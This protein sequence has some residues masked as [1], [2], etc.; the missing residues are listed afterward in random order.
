MIPNST[1]A[2][3]DDTLRAWLLL[4]LTPRIGIATMLKLIHHFGSADCIIDQGI[5]TLSQFIPKTIARLIVD[6]TAQ[7]D[8]EIALDWVN[9]AKNRYLISL[10]NPTYPK[11]LA[12]ISD[13]PLILYAE[14]NLSLLQENKLAIVGTRHPTAQG[15]ENATKFAK[16][17]AKNLTIVSGMALGIDRH[18]HIGAL[19]SPKSTIGV[20]GTGIDLVYPSSNKDIFEQVLD[21]G[22][23]IS[24]LPLK[25]PALMN[26]F[27][28]R[29]RIIAGLSKG[30][31][32][33]ESAKDGGSLITAN[34]ALDMG[35]EVM[36]IPGSIYNPVACGCH[37]LIKNGAKLIE[38]TNDVLEEL[39]LDQVAT[40]KK[41]STT[42]N[43]PLLD[44]M[45]FD[46]IEIDKICLNSNTNFNDICATL[47]DLELNGHIINCG[48][49]KYQR[50]FR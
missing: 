23:L 13:P 5:D 17:L 7:K 12:Q 21:K 50:V 6:K 28:R 25:T 9:K 47:L 31:L 26:N 29:N 33:I 41:N 27:P 20:I 49:G 15:I 34:C 35:R 2:S 16:D 42:F 1:L 46:P 39:I 8:V 3:S 36:A 4:A 45:G 48:N 10:N 40:Q 32:V 44:T 24:E 14:G 30:C 38:N 18:A 37:K 19:Q 11:E 22:L 43:H